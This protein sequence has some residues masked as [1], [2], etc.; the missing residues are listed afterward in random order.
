MEVAQ[1]NHESEA[2]GSPTEPHAE[3][4]NTAWYVSCR[5]QSF[6]GEIRTAL[7]R[8]G[9]LLLFYGIQLVHYLA[10]AERT[11][12]EILFHRQVTF[13]VAGWLA[14]SL[15]V[16]VALRQSYFPETLKFLTCGLDVALLAVAAGLGS[17][18]NSPLIPCFLLV[19]GT[20]SLRL[21]MRLVT[22]ATA[23]S[24]LCYLCLVGA[25]DPSWFDADHHT[26]PVRQLV[27]ITCMLA[28]GV[29]AGQIILMQRSLASDYAR[30]LGAS[31]DTS[32]PVA[33]DNPPSQSASPRAPGAL[34]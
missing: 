25:F 34:E 8:V 1:H 19:I 29:I 32:H 13:L 15:M 6:D 31:K 33:D 4:A 23:V 27:V 5:W 18:P 3:A 14:V 21:S 28:A 12:A 16:L 22:F 30:R 2:E 26:P 10:F 9:L 7:M 20:T 17:G 24:I 11:E